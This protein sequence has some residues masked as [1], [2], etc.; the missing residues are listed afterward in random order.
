[1]V[2]HMTKYDY[3]GP[4]GIVFGALAVGVALVW[5]IRLLGF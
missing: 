5:V 2:N 1:M 3:V 4:I